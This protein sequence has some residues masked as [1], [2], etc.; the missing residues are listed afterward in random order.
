LGKQYKAKEKNPEER[1]QAESAS[2]TGL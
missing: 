1:G 2:I